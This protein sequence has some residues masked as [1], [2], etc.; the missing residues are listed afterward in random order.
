[1]LHSDIFNAVR[2]Y[3]L[4]FMG[5]AESLH[6]NELDNS[7]MNNLATDPYTHKVDKLFTNLSKTDEK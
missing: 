6:R 2:N 4:L 7:D 5:N 3:F 1:M